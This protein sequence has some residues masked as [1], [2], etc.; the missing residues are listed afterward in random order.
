VL[1]LLGV[2]LLAVIGWVACGG[3]SPPIFMPPSG[4]TPAGNYV[5]TVTA[6]SGNLTH[7]TM[8]QLTVR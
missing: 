6:T 3:G 7:S 1:V 4:G 5:L 8:A 2:L